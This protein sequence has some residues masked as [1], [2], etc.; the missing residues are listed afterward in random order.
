MPH[1]SEEIKKTMVAKL[2]A[3]GA[4]SAFQLGKKTGISQTALSRWVRE[5]GE[6][7]N[8]KN[9]RPED[10]SPEERLNA[11]FSALKLSDQ[12]LGEF[13][14]KNGLHSSTIEDWKKEALCDASNKKKVGRPRKDPELVAS[15][16][17]IKLLKRDL[18]RKDRALAE[19]SAI[20]ILQK[21]VQGLWATDED[22]A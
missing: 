17:E 19:Q 13:L 21:K 8:V 20:I 16:A 2:C 11:V 12:E 22:D 7:T 5:L 14:R 3:P 1:Y 6:G 10:W 15:E 4:P 9:R 18:N